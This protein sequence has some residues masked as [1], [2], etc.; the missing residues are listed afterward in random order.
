MN[1][2]V[3]LF[4]ALMSSFH[5]NSFRVKSDQENIHHGIHY[6]FQMAL[7]KCILIYRGE[8]F[9]QSLTHT[10]IPT[11]KSTWKKE[12]VFLSQKKEVHD[13]CHI[14]TWQSIKSCVFKIIKYPLLKNC[15]N[16][17]VMFEK[18]RSDTDKKIQY[19][20]NMNMSSVRIYLLLESRNLSGLLSL[21]YNQFETDYLD[22]L[23][24]LEGPGFPLLTLL[25]VHKTIKRKKK[26]IREQWVKVSIQSN[27]GKGLQTYLYSFF[28]IV[29]NILNFHFFLPA[30][31]KT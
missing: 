25:S 23:A 14:C 28:D 29:F 1:N 9:L 17:I 30:T 24:R 20:T 11:V 19:Q 8:D 3:P 2:V 31:K 13:L 27:L 5:N 26:V 21:I 6:A 10:T 18:I 22:W 16:Y 15:L 12:V 4:W 7:L